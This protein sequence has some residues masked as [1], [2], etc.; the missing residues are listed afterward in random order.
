MTFKYSICH[1]DKQ[2]VEY[3]NTPITADE[4][5]ELARNYPWLEQLALMDS[6]D[7]ESIHGTP[8]LD[9]TNIQD[10]RS[11]CLTASADEN[12]NLSFSLWYNRPKK[13]K[14][15][16][17]LLGE[18]EVMTV[19]DYWSLDFNESTKYL[20]HFVNRDYEAVERLYV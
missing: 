4:V 5:L 7:P 1:P 10:G 20:K 6:I 12:N 9:F 15:L 3:I 8:S 18:K 13:V 16:F 17:G 19:D 2:D 11:F 14:V